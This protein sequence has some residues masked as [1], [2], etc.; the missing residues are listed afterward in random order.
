VGQPEQTA[1]RFVDDPFAESDG[2]RMYATGDLARRLPDGTI[3]FL[4][5]AD[6]QLKIR[7]FRVEP[8]EVEAALRRGEAVRDALVLALDDGHDGRRL[9]AYVAAPPTTEVD[10]VRR[11]AAEWVPDFMLP[12]AIV[13]VDEFP[14]T[15]SGKVDRQALPDPDQTVR[16]YIAPRTPTEEAVAAIWSNVLAIE[17]VSVDDDFFAIGGHSLLATQIVAQIRSDFS[18]DL[19]LHA[20]FTSP[21]VATLSEQVARLASSVDDDATADLLAELEGLSEEDAERLLAGEPE[22]DL[23]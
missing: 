5:R 17:K 13:R 3:E 7:G 2:A 4:G 9:V 15:P 18:V 11:K 22:R 12:S 14:R 19:P 1:E 10:D 8:A 16:S 23:T 6:D 21:T 20:L